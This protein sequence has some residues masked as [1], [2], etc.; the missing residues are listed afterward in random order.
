[1]NNQ[2]K[3]DVTTEKGELVIRTGDAAPI[4]MPVKYSFD[5]L[6]D[7][8]ALFYAGRYAANP[9]Y[10]NAKCAVI[11]V[12][13][14]KRTIKL[15]RDVNDPKSD[16]I[17]G[18]IFGES[19]LPPFKI[20]T[21]DSWR[22]ADLAKFLKRNKM[23]FDSAD[24]NANVVAKLGKLKVETSGEIVVENDN[25]GNKEQSFKMKT[26]SEIPESFTLKMPIFSNGEKLAFKV[27]IEFDVQGSTVLC[28]LESDDLYQQTID[29]IKSEIEKQLAAFKDSGIPILFK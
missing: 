14:N 6:I 15:I 22:P 13:L 10:F 1:M 16:E 29:G 2:I 12:E 23:H 28:F 11:M 24:V 8:P 9:A 25:R 5:G 19:L 3:L 4:I 7:A 27:D 20:N 21:G 18:T 26:T 17:T